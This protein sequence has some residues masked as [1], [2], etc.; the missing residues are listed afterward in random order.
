MS[1]DKLKNKISDLLVNNNEL[2]DFLFRFV[3][4]NSYSAASFNN[5]HSL[6]LLFEIIL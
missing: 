4:C 5:S 2:I 6:Q 1:F 3:K